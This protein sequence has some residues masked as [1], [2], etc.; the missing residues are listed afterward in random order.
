MSED[1]FFAVARVSCAQIFRAAGIERCSPQILD[2]LTDIFIRHIQLLATSSTRYAELCGNSEVNIKDVQLA[3]EQRGVVRPRALL[4]YDD[5][6]PWGLAGWLGFIEWAEG[7]IP[8]ETRRISQIACQ[9]NPLS[10]AS[11]MITGSE[12]VAQAVPKQ[13]GSVDPI[14]SDEIKI[15]KEEDDDGLHG[16]QESISDNQRKSAT[17]GVGVVA[18]TALA[19]TTSTYN[20]EWLKGLMK[21]QAKV[22]YEARFK[23]TVLA[24]DHGVNVPIDPTIAGGPPTLQA[25]YDMQEEKLKEQLQEFHIDE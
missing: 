9:T 23:G 13:V 19:T 21:V 4:D 14:A 3:M 24:P 16:R 25:F 22:D 17:P 20:E 12:P 10:T 7:P 5:T 8:K 18:S 1:F 6:N 11:V 15:K 2:I